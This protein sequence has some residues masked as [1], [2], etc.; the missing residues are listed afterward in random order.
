MAMASFRHE[1][2]GDRTGGASAAVIR[3]AQRKDGGGFL[4]FVLKSECGATL[5]DCLTVH[6]L[7]AFSNVLAAARAPVRVLVL[8]VQVKA[9]FGVRWT[10]R[11][12]AEPKAA[13][14]TRYR[15]LA[16]VRD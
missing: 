4:Q 5:F 16:G 14:R 11:R 1:A 2:T 8:L 3:V 9:L 6:V 13:L 7:S 12:K 15:S 10:S